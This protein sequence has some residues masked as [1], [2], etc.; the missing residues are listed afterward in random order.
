MIYWMIPH[1]TQRLLSPTLINFT[2][3]VDKESHV[4]KCEVKIV[5]HSVLEWI[6]NFI[7][8]LAVIGLVVRDGINVNP[9]K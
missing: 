4:I 1:K 3:N 2:S 7:Q 6:S 9:W 8:H 5:A